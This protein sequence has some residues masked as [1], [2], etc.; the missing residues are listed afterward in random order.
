MAKKT[1]ARPAGPTGPAPTEADEKTYPCVKYRKVPV[2]VKYP[3]GYEVKR[4]VDDV[5]EARLGPEWKDSPA[6]L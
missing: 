6:D 4:C 3:N 2:S 5:A 1:M